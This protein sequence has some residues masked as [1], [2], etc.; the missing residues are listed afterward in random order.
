MVQP[1]Y[2]DIVCRIEIGIACPSTCRVGACKAFA[3]TSAHMQARMAHLGGISRWDEYQQYACQ[4]GF[5]LH[6]LSQ[7]EE[8]PT[9]AAAPL[10]FR[11]RLLVGTLANAGQVFEG[12]GGLL[13]LRYLHKGFRDAMV[14]AALKTPFPP[15]QPD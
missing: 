11:S 5:V 10:G 14:R 15:R 13:G 9:I 6:K 8:G 3:L 1:Q 7:L 2:A 12:K 4:C